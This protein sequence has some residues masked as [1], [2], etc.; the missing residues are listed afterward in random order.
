M[1]NACYR[2]GVCAEQA[3]LA[4][5]LQTFGLDAITH[6]VIAGGPEGGGTEPVMP[7]GGCRQAIAEAA[8]LAGRDIPVTCAGSEGEAR[9]HTT[10]S[11]LLP[12]AFDLSR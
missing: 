6:V 10:S 4:A 5:A 3:A 9:R 12:D 2:L 8:S 11:A 7:C 1:E